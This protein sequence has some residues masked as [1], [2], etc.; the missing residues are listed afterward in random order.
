MK[1]QLVAIA[2]A[3][4]ATA[5]LSVGAPAALAGPRVDWSVS[6]G[7]PGDYQP[8]PYV[9]PYGVYGAPPAVY[10][11]PSYGDSYGERRFDEQAGHVTPFYLSGGL[12]LPR[13]LVQTTSH[14][15]GRAAK[16]AHQDMA[17]RE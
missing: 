10:V 17:H 4:I 12:N 9:Q 7:A 1:K 14:G 5:A 16:Q 6:V 8:D 15:P 11:T 13:T 2:S 3:L